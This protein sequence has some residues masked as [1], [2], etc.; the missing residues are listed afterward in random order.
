LSSPVASSACSDGAFHMWQTKS[1]F[2]RPNMSIENAFSKGTETG[3]VVFSVDGRSVLTRS[4]DDT[5]KCMVFPNAGLML[6]K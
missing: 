5:V 2:V 4:G 3:S 6:L 1:N